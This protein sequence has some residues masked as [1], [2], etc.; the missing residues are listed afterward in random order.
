MEHE[1]SAAVSAKATFTEEPKWTMVMAK[2]VHQVVSWVVE[3][4]V[5]VPK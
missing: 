5:D 4:L 1:A 3:T 2:N